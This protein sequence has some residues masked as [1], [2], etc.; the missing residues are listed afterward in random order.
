MSRARG[1]FASAAIAVAG[2]S[3]VAM[4]A[5]EPS[6]RFSLRL[7][8]ERAHQLSGVAGF[9]LDLPINR[10]AVAGARTSMRL[11]P[12]E[13]LLVDAEA[14]SDALERELTIGLGAGFRSLVDISHRQGAIAI[15]GTS[16]REGI[17]GGCPLDLH[18]S[19]FPPGSATRTVFG[20]AE[21]ILSRPT[22]ALTYHVECWRS[23][24]PYVIA[25]AQDIA[26]GLGAG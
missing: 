15:S 25:L 3:A 16:A 19:A 24:A 20:K 14:S 2:T 9:A 5:L 18:D 4:V 17:N 11:G 7:R 8:A 6:T 21:I 23:F 26:R 12:D 10:C 1:G 13:W 22:A